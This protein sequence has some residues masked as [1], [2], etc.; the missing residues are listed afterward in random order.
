[1]GLIAALAL[2]LA[3]IPSASGQ[4]PDRLLLSFG[5]TVAPELM[6]DPP[7]A[8][9]GADFPGIAVAGAPDR[10]FA[11]ADFGDRA[12]VLCWHT[13]LG[14]PE[15]DTDFSLTEFAAQIDAIR[16]LG[17]S[18]PT[19]EDFLAGRISGTKNVIVTID[20]GNHSVPQA[21]QKVL[22]PRGIVPTLFVYPAVLGTTDF[23]MTDTQLAA[24]VAEGVPAGAHGYHHL[25]VTESLYRESP[26]EFMDE[27]YKSKAKSEALSKS[28]I[29]AYAYPYGAL[30][31]RTETEVDKAGFAAAFAVKP[32]FVFAKKSLDELYDLPRIVVLRSA[33]KDI[34]ALLARNAAASPAK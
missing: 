4:P 19:V 13:F 16:A 21:V 8:N 17:Y 12:L 26:K 10:G 15:F 18:F 1:M 25:R 11:V 6:A 32:G 7:E 9:G 23:S 33:W 14:K 27:I 3:P 31:A 34:Y 29:L 24:L 2:W 30:S 22:L 20:D 28:P 5:T